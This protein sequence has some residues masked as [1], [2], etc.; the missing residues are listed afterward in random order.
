MVSVDIVKEMIKINW[1]RRLDTCNLID[2]I[3]AIKF[4]SDGKGNHYNFSVPDSLNTEGSGFIED[5]ICLTTMLYG[6]DIDTFKAIEDW[7]MVR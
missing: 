7:R 4:I 2:A 3:K 5:E 6:M 1:S